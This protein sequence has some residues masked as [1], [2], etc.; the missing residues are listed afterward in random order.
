[1]TCW[2]NG[3]GSLLIGFS[4]SQAYVHTYMINTQIDERANSWPGPCVGL[5]PVLF[6]FAFSPHPDLDVVEWQ[7]LNNNFL[8]FPCMPFAMCVMLC[9]LS[10]CML[11]IHTCDIICC[12]LSCCVVRHVVCLTVCMMSYVVCYVCEPCCEKHVSHIHNN[13]QHSIYYVVPHT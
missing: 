2:V 13:K 8:Y 11:Y 10:S 9:R 12:Y 6:C 3:R 7:E 4:D 1:M 5:F